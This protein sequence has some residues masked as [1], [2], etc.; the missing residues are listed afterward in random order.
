MVWISHET[1]YF[2]DLRVRLRG[3]GW[4]G[5]SREDEARCCKYF[6]ALADRTYGTGGEAESSSLSDID[7]RARARELGG[8]ADTYFEAFCLLQAEQRRKVVWG[9]KTPRHVFRIDDIITAFPGARIVCLLRD[10][11]A[12]VASY[13]DSLGAP[14]TGTFLPEHLTALRADRDRARKS[15]HV[16]T[17]A[18]LWRAAMRAA[19]DGQMHYGTDRLRIERYESLATRPEETLKSLAAWLELGY[20]S[21]MLDVEIVR[22][23]YPTDRSRGISSG[24]VARWRTELSALELAAIQSCCGQ[25]LQETG[26]EPQLVR[27]RRLRLASLWATLPIAVARAF[28]ANRQRI[29]RRLDY[30]AR[31]FALVIK[32]AGSPLRKR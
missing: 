21:A 11:R 22:S 1:H 24:P 17:A 27:V 7:L 5:L 18:L 14:F 13:R 16:L 3:N 9:E 15:Y 12:V 31:R 29:G 25:M 10:P 32:G 28:I 4:K 30:V 19:Y 23:S 6:L 26:Y 2:D 8:G 20:E